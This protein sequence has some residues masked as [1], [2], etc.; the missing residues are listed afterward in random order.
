MTDQTPGLFQ[1]LK[2][3]FCSSNKTDKGEMAFKPD[4]KACEPTVK[5][6]LAPSTAGGANYAKNVL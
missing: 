4:M 6:F 5:Y 2:N 3:F 1:R